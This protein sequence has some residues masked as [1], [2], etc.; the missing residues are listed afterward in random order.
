MI[1]C[2]RS[3]LVPLI[4]RMSKLLPY[5]YNNN[6]RMLMLGTAATESLLI[7][8]VQIGGPARGLWQMEPA[9]AI[10]LYNDFLKY[11]ASSKGIVYEVSGI[12]K[13]P[14]R[15]EI[16]NLLTCSD[17]Y[18]CI[19]ARL[20]YAWDK[21]PVPNN[22]ND[23]AKYYKRVYNTVLGKGSTDKF[24]RDYNRLECDKLIKEYLDAQS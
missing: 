9:T 10:S 17:E 24:I 2:N 8:R 19:M 13:T 1:I 7:H 14:T 16:I 3:E 20:R 15:E 6:V 18:A 4:D 21:Y 22:I 23:I 5:G 12:Y 11:R